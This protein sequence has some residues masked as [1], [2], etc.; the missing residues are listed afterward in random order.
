MLPTKTYQH[1]LSLV[2]E[3]QPD[4]RMELSRLMAAAVIN[5]KF[6]NLLLTDPDLALK[7]GFQGEDFSFSP[8]G[9]DLILSI[10]TNSLPDL[11][12]QLARTLNEHLPLKV[13]PP[14]QLANCFG[15]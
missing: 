4:D 8:G 1:T 13:N 3:D 5:P 9:R 7:T 6:C 12:N 11:A 10:R 2:L 15:Y 14:V